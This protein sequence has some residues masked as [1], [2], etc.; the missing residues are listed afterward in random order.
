[1]SQARSTDRHGASCVRLAVANQKG[2]V[3]KTTTVVNLGAALA[4]AGARVL[5]VDLDAQSC[6]TFALG[7]DPETVEVTMGEVIVDGAPVA[8]AVVGTGEGLDLLPGSIELAAAE[9]ALLAMPDGRCVLRE[10]L[11]PLAAA[12]DVLLLDCAPSLGMLTLGALAAADEVLVPL[13]CEMLAHRGVGQ[14]LD[15]VAD[16]TRLLNP[17][18]R[19]RGLLPTMY[20]GRSNHARAVLADLPGRYRQPVLDPIPRSIRFAEA[21]ALG[22]SVLRTARGARAAHAYRALAADLLADWAGQ[23]T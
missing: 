22:R 5:V 6:L 8:E 1:M 2:G 15:T 4:E 21:A 23:Q 9:A 19:V 7:V 14:L 11:E 13:Q 16:V 18:L 20:D 3:A 12:Y 17:R 10:T